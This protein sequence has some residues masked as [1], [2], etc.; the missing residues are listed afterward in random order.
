[1]YIDLIKIDFKRHLFFCKIDILIDIGLYLLSIIFN[2]LCNIYKK[3]KMPNIIQKYMML[4]QNSNNEYI[5]RFD[6]L[7]LN[8]LFVK[9]KNKLVIN[10]MSNN[11]EINEINKN[12]KVKNKNKKVK[13]RNIKDNEENE[14]LFTK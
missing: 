7:S 2:F 5:K 13:N 1:M 6:S 8:N 10:K 3:S 4:I 11:I 14:S 12:K 9:I